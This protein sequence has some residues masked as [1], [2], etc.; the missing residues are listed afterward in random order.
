MRRTIV[1]GKAESNGQMLLEVDTL[2][3]FLDE[4][5][6]KRPSA[7]GTPLA[8]DETIYIFESGEV[9]SGKEIIYRMNT[10]PE[11][12][13]DIID[14]NQSQDDMTVLD[15]NTCVTLSM[16]LYEGKTSKIDNSAINFFFALEC[17]EHDHGLAMPAVRLAKHYPLESI[18]LLL[19][20]DEN[21]RDSAI[22]GLLRA[23][24]EGKMP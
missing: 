8:H 17:K 5:T 15:L 16:Y 1:Q 11:L 10:H 12:S 14:Y 22:G 23:R 3:L 9:L 21:L 13:K 6:L 20:T 4:G 18:P 19:L 7:N 2:Y 24:L